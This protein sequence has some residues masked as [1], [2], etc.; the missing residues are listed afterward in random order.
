MYLGPDVDLE[1]VEEV[2]KLAQ[3]ESSLLLLPD[4][5]DAAVAKLLASGLVIGRCHGAMEFGQRSLGNRAILADPTV[6]DLVA[7]INEMIKHRDFWM[8]FAP[9]LLDRF[10]DE[11]LENPKGIDAPHMTLAFPTT[12]KG[13]AAMRAA[14]HPAD[15]TARAQI[16]KK[17][18]NPDLYRLL[19]HFEQLTGRGSLLNTSFNL[20][21]SPIVNTALE[22]WDV[23]MRTGLE[24]LWLPGLLIGKKTALEQHGVTCGKN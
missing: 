11:Y 6:P 2:R 8:P 14:C 7:K 3:A 20:H 18:D 17:P 19:E 12:E 23:F 1:G 5:G 24:C 13:F 4:S 22:A 9:V 10:A 21:G 15:R 16:L